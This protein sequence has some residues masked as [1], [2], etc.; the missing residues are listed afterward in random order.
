MISTELQDVLAT[1]RQIRGNDRDSGTHYLL[2]YLWAS[3]PDKEKAR[4]AT[5]F[6]NDLKEMET[7]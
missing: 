7:K 3:I 5:L 4:I 1:C 2:G 6:N